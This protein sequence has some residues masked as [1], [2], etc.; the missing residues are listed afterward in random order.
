[1]VYLLGARHYFMYFTNINKVYIKKS[2]EADIVIP[3]YRAI[4]NK[5]V[6]SLGFTCLLR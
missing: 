4:A 5:F 2:H 3:S 6:I 1:M